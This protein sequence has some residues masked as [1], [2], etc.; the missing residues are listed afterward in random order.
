[1]YA[2]LLVISS[3][4]G[5]EPLPDG[6]LLFLENCNKFVEVYTRDEIGHVAMV[7]SDEATIWVYE[8]TP[9]QVRRVTLAAYYDELARINDRRREKIE[10]LAYK[11]KEPFSA[12]EVETMRDYLDSQL[13]RRYSL[14]NYVTKQVG[15]GTHCAEL[16]A[17]TINRSERF[18][19]SEPKRISPGALQ[20]KI[21]ADYQPLE[22]IALPAYEEQ[23]TWCQRTVR[24]WHSCTKWCSWSWGEAWAFCW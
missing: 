10:V 22:V 16:T 23:E 15:D 17:N 3:V 21:A 9:G 2:F 7:F 8:A 4:V 14:L 12:E 6:T 18:A 13:G 24:K 1:M 5:A 19:F 20:K 11:P